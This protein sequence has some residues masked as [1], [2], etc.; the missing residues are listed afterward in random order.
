M[1]GAAIAFALVMA[2]AGVVWWV[3][4]GRGWR[5]DETAHVPAAPETVFAIL[6]DPGQAPRLD[7]RTLSARR[8]GD[9]RELYVLRR[10]GLTYEAEFEVVAR[11]PPGRLVQELVALRRRGRPAST[12]G[13]LQT[14]ELEPDGDGTKVRLTIRGAAGSPRARIALGAAHDGEAR[15][16]RRV[17]ARLAAHAGDA[18]PRR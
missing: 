5:V 4:G 8:V 10:G 14:W 13:Q 9:R 6:D 2:I 17:L 16:V 11:E 12:P 3:R 1:A 18:A 7:P 15:S